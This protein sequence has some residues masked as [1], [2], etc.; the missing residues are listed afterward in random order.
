MLIKEFGYMPKS[1]R[2]AILAIL[3]LA[4]L[5]G[6]AF[7]ALNFI[8]L[9]SNTIKDD[10]KN[11]NASIRKS[12]ARK[13][14][15]KE[16]TY[17]VPA[18]KTELFYF[19]PNT[20]DSTQLLRLGLQPWQVRNIYKYR[21]KGGIYRNKEDFAFVYGLT[22]KDYKRLAPYI[23]IAEDYQ[24]A[25]SLAEVRR[26]DRYAHVQSPS[27]TTEDA[28]NV[29][30]VKPAYS[31]KLHRGEH[32]AI[33]TSDTTALKTIPGIGSYFA[34][35]TVRYRELLGGFVKKEQLLEIDEFPKEALEYI[36]VDRDNIKKL[37]VNKLSV[38]QLR[39]HPYIN[40]YQARAIS[41]YRRLHGEIKDINELK[42]MREF[43]EYD[44]NR[45]QPYLSY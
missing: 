25:S 21:A 4:T 13:G 16:Y 26:R 6:V 17:A 8:G 30:S 44:I 33:N 28:S 38:S 9:K 15:K 36:D 27:S 41:D 1:D 5:I 23:R 2:R 45:I 10:G 42:L 34:R 11:T 35:R 43:S 18:R 12:T 20:A 24:P 3:V 14:N 39:R 32:I 37:N 22:V 40:Y 7:F 19:D 29:K 31:P